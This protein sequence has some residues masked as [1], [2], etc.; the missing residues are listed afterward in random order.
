MD[1]KDKIKI[2]KAIAKLETFKKHSYGA[3]ELRGGNQMMSRLD[4]VQDTALNKRISAK[5]KELR[6]KKFLKEMDYDLDSDSVDILKIFGI[7]KK[8]KVQIHRGVFGYL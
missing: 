6:S 5:Q 3:S 2:N 8:E 7:K 4:R 1:I